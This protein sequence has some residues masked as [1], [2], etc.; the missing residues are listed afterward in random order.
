ML[1]YG[2]IQYP[3]HHICRPRGLPPWT[4]ESRSRIRSCRR[5]SCD[6]VSR[7]ST[8]V[9]IFREIRCWF[10]SLIAQCFNP[11]ISWISL[12]S[13]SPLPWTTFSLQFPRRGRGGLPSRPLGLLREVCVFSEG[14]SERHDNM[15]WKSLGII[16]GVLVVWIGLTRWVLPWCG[17]ET[18][19]SA[20]RC[21]PISTEPTVLPDDSGP[22]H[23]A[24]PESNNDA[25]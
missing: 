13:G 5:S 15:D 20:K 7:P 9:V 6:G 17:V 11:S 10:E 25:P 4:T 3:E 2:N 8:S 19:C 14:L 24:G 22:P 12:Y 18:C 1:L 23:Q 21:C 16:L